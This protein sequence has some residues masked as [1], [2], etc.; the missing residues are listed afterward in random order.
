MAMSRGILASLIV[1]ISIFPGAAL[2]A[3]GKSVFAGLSARSNSSCKCI[4]LTFLRRNDSNA[5]TPQAGDLKIVIDGKDLTESDLIFGN[6]INVEAR[7]QPLAPG[8]EYSFNIGLDIAQYFPEHRDYRV[9]WKGADFQS[10]AILVRG[11]LPR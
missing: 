3:E 8:Q 11:G 4:E 7:Y 6:G 1:S 9:S 10:E 5:R 2:P